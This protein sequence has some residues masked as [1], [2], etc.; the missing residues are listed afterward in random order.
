MNKLQRLQARTSELYCNSER[1][2]LW[3]CTVFPIPVSI[4]ASF[5][6][7]KQFCIDRYRSLVVIIR[8][9]H[10]MTPMIPADFK[11]WP[12]AHNV[13]VNLK[14]C[15]CM[16]SP[17]LPVHL[18]KYK[19]VFF[20]NLQMRTLFPSAICFTQWSNI[21]LQLFNSMH[22]GKC[23]VEVLILAYNTGIFHRIFCDLWFVALGSRLSALCLGLV[24][25]WAQRPPAP[26]GSSACTSLSAGIE[27]RLLPVAVVLFLFSKTWVSRALAKC[28]TPT[29]PILYCCCSWG[30]ALNC[31]GHHCN[32]CTCYDC[33]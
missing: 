2:L 18:H 23:S 14:Y 16:P 26:I 25:H 31:C 30:G 32:D 9:H 24:D 29:L 3:T 12:F 11:K 20:W 10:E 1:D 33:A 8:R 28:S 13:S 22:D 4:S 21:Q 19:Y 5:L 7:I 6:Y 15:R 27:L 17:L